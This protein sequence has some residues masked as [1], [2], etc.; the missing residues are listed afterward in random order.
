MKSKNRTHKNKDIDHAE[1]MTVHSIP[2]AKDGK[3]KKEE[4]LEAIIV[5]NDI[6]L[7]LFK[8]ILTSNS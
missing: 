6:S 1:L 8:H 5:Q 7:I 4:S 2:F 3:K